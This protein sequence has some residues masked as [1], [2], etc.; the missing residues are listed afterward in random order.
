MTADDA[1]D[2]LINKKALAI[3]VARRDAAAPDRAPD[4]TTRIEQRGDR[5]DATMRVDDLLDDQP[6]DYNPMGGGSSES[7][8]GMYSHP[9]ETDLDA[10]PDDD[11]VASAHQHGARIVGRDSKRYVRPGGSGQGND[12]DTV[13]YAE[14]AEVDDREP[15]E[16]G[17]GLARRVPRFAYLPLA[18]MEKFETQA[19]DMLAALQSEIP[20]APSLA[21]TSPVRGE[22]RTELAIRLAL[23][24]AKK[25]GHRVLLAD[26]DVRKPGIAGRLGLTTKYFTTMDV[27]RGSCRLGEAL[28]ASEE[29][30]LYVL[31]ARDADRDG[32]EIL[33]DRQVE[34]M[35]SEVHQ[36]FDFAILDCGPAGQADALVV[37]RLAGS[38][39]IAGR[40]R[41]SYAPMM[42]LA[43]EN[44]AAAGAKIAGMVITDN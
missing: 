42:R 31:P 35:L 4:D 30:N 16:F 8:R 17:L 29:D 3:P 21:I 40:C 15:G 28:F 19:R 14:A 22:G 33:D 23:V 41:R 27:L 36:A 11:G 6:G 34:A 37:C 7:E 18:D 25:V 12:I 32:D 24:L 5:P 26:M 44:L 39:A 13:E 38:V 43:V 9:T 1:F 20:D 10:V 2:N